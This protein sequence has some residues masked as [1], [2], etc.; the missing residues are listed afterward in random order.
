MENKTKLEIGKVYSIDKEEGFTY[1]GLNVVQEHVFARY[2]K[3]YNEIL[4][5]LIEK[6]NV[7]INGTNVTSKDNQYPYSFVGVDEED[8]GIVKIVKEGLFSNL[9]KK[10]NIGKEK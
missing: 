10:I 9:L 1:T 5:S 8:S 6:E 4:L 2:I 7:E 3:E